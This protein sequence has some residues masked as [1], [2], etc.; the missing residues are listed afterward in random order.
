MAKISI[1]QKRLENLR[2]QLYGK[3][4]LIYKKPPVDLPALNNVLE[5][6]NQPTVVSTT[7]DTSH[8]KKD[9]IKIFILSI[10]AVGI[11]LTLYFLSLKNFINLNINF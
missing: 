11:Q 6:K 3:E 10:L 8:L 2:R 5:S 4:K 7:L 9:L 1:D